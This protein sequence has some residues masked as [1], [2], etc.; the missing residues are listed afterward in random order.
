M[1]VASEAASLPA[2]V[3][4][5]TLLRKGSRLLVAC[6]EDTWLDLLELQMEGKRRVPVEAFLNGFSLATGERLDER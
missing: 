1:R 4:S 3:P 5:G 2:G 6:G